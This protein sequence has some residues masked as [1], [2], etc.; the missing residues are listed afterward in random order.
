MDLVGGQMVTAA[1]IPEPVSATVS[2]TRS[3]AA[4]SVTVMPPCSVAL[5]A[6]ES[7]FMTIRSHRSRSR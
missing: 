2:A 7:R 5:N 1:G 4:S 3:P 6:L